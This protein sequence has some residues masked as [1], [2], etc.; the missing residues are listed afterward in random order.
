MSSPTENDTGQTPEMVSEYHRE[1]EIL[2]HIPLFQNLEHECLKLIAVICK[3]VSFLPGEN[4]M[5][6]GEEGENGYYI[7]SGDIAALHTIDD[8][9]HHVK[10]FGA[11][12]FVGGCLLLGKIQHAFTVQART[13][14][15][16]LCLNRTDF[17]KVLDLFPASFSQI[18][19]RLIAELVI[20][21]QNMLNRSFSKQEDSGKSAHLPST[22]GVSLI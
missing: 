10:Q 15:T 2:R 5:V 11:G 4:L 22:P 17:C 14:A 21:D 8:I 9:E 1:L 7:I 16:V 12:D 20:W 3:K 18:T 19:R 6:Q 13:K